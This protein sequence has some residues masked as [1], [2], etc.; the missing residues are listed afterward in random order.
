[1]KLRTYVQKNRRFIDQVINEQTPEQFMDDPI[2]DDEREL[3]VLNDE[4]LYLAA[5]REGVDI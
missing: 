2:D 4:G 5:R 1:M 3:W